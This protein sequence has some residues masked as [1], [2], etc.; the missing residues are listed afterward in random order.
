MFVQT[1]PVNSDMTKGILCTIDFSDASKEALRWS[2]ALAESLHTHLTILHTFRLFNA[3]LEVEAPELK[4]RIEEN[5]K[6][7]FV[8]LE[9]ELLSGK[10]ISY[11]FKIEVGFV[12][13]RVKDY[14]KKHGLS[15]LVV[16]DT[17][18]T[19]NRESF[20]ELAKETG[21]PLVIVP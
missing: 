7:Q 4:R 8:T 19:N 20:D 13:N 3:N 10:G 21:V 2:V 1:L 17:M 18:R 9:K 16:G 14:S 11:E 5:A 12:T 6:L 15:F